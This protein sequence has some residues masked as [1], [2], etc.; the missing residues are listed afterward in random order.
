MTSPHSPVSP[1]P[2]APP[3]L[4]IAIAQMEISADARRNGLTV[5]RL[6]REAAAAGARLV[7]FPEGCLSGCAK[8]QIADWGQVD[9]A[10]VDEEHH[11]IAALAAELRL[12]VVLGSTH[13]LTPPHRPHNSLYV[14]ADDGRLVGRYDKR[15]CSHTEL[16]SYYTP[17]TAPTTFTVDGFTFGCAI[18]VEINFP[19]L[20]EEYGR[21]GVD[22]LLLSAYPVDSI[23]EVKARAH[24]ATHNYWLAMATPAQTTHLLT[25][26]LIGPNGTVLVRADATAEL[27]IGELDRHSPDFATALHT[28]RPWR[29]SAREGEI[30]R[31]RRVADPRSVELT[32]F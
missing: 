2:P 18:C 24:A 7:Q 3:P 15:Y 23:F 4:R 13:R 19:P 20:F 6:M 8:E 5:R 10:A 25:C 21:L 14:I 28:V 9:W 12:W 30:Y 22:C 1:T 27:L 17:G 31:S 29:A 11:L 26:E 32:A 16:T